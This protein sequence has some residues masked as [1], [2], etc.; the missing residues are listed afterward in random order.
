MPAKGTAEWKGDLRSG[1][2]T[3]TAGDTQQWRIYVQLT[4][5]SRA[6]ASVP[7]IMLEALAQ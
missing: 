6:L 4:L 3:F 5:L 1:T 2:G 7:E